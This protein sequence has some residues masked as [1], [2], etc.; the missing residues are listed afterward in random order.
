[1]IGISIRILIVDDEPPIRRFL[2]TSLTAHG[3]DVIEAVNGADAVRKTAEDRPD[4]LILDLGLPDMDGADVIRKIREWAETPIIVL[5]VRDRETDKITALDRGA[6]DYVVKPFGMGELLA[7]IRA[8]LRH[9][10]RAETDD[11][12][13]RTG[14]LTVDLGKRL[15]W[16]DNEEVKLTPTEYDLLR[17]F[18]AHAGKVLTHH[19]ILKEVWGPAGTR[20]T[21]Y[22]RVYVGQL[23]KK[24]EENPARPLYLVTEPGV[25]YRLQ[26]V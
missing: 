2:R 15:V 25:G 3:Y 20:Q 4:L 12:I 13:F 22:L 16:L 10:L 18:V 1:M 19:Q 11:P 23:R 8:V 6:D 21:H 24:L 9:R 17:L 5:S 14:R 7:R 26:E